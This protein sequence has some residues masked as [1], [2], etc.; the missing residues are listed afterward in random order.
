MQLSSRV[1]PKPDGFSFLSAIGQLENP[2]PRQVEV[3][4]SSHQ[5]STHRGP[6]LHTVW[7]IDKTGAP[8]KAPMVVVPPP[9]L[10]DGRQTVLAFLA[11]VRGCH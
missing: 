3:V 9:A 4:S 2:P 1:T 5:G 7:S 6:K 8:T 11:K 10:Q